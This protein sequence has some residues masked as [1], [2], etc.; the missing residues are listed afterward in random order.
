MEGLDYIKQ[1]PFTL[2]Y[3]AYKD[4]V[5]IDIYIKQKQVITHPSPHIHVTLIN[6]YVHLDLCKQNM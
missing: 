2:V 6:I 4:Y 5:Y 3:E 1:I